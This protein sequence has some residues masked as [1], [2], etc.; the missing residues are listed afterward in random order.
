MPAA[1]FALSLD[2]AR[3]DRLHRYADAN[4][5][6]AAAVI[7]AVIDR[8]PTPAAEPP[9]GAAD[10]GTS[11]VNV[12]LP[13][14]ALANLDERVRSAGFLNRTT[15]ARSLL[16]HALDG[17]PPLSDPEIQALRESRRELAALGRN[18][19]QIARSLNTDNDAEG[20]TADLLQTTRDSINAHR[21]AVNAVIRKAEQRGV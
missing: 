7:K 1:R 13:D 8:L 10:P 14:A 19:N 3:K 2:H 16:L 17:D 20:P 15:C 18:L 5:V 11:Q 9:A 12:R 4:G 21:Q 6:S